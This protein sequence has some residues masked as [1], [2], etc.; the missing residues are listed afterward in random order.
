M[1]FAFQSHRRKRDREPQNVWNDDDDAEIAP[2][3]DEYEEEWQEEPVQPVEPQRR[4]LVLNVAAADRLIR[5]TMTQAVA[6]A[7]GG[8]REKNSTGTEVG[9]RLGSRKPAVADPDEDDDPPELSSSPELQER[10]LK[11]SK[12][13]PVKR[14]PQY[15]EEE[16]EE[17]DEEEYEDEEEAEEEAAEYDE[18]LDGETPRRSSFGELT[19]GATHWLGSTWKRADELDA[20]RKRLKS[21][22]IKRRRSQSMTG[23]APLP[24]S[25]ADA[26]KQPALASSLAIDVRSSM[27]SSMSTHLSD[28]QSPPPSF[29]KLHFSLTSPRPP[30]NTPVNPTHLHLVYA[31]PFLTRLPDGG[32]GINSNS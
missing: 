22:T 19:H 20:D 29:H 4:R 17:Y 8:N 15:V 5:N 2:E 3:E 16:E 26:A 14:K 31:I 23:L 9:S 32:T 21:E 6:S 11:L 27:V 18:E 10:P 1:A 13:I 28:S 24:S 12:P 7:V 30:P 25:P